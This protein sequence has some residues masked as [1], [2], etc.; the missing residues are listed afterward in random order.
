M[1]GGAGSVIGM[2]FTEWLETITTD[3]QADVAKAIGMSRRTLQNQ[4]YGTPKIETIIK[5]ADEYHSNPLVA[6]VDLGY[7]EPHWLE[8]LVGNLEAAGAAM[9]PGMVADLA[10]KHILRGVES[11]AFDT[12]VDELIERRRNRQASFDPL[13][14]VAT[15]DDQDKDRY[16]GDDDD[17]P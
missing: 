3:S 6:L 10:V 14:D 8:S 16:P 12:P 1:C 13:R 17:H 2:N 15:G 4:L 7:V 9:S 5:I 11:D